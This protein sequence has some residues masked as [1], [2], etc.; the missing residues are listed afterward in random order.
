MR[1]F[2]TLIAITV[3]FASSCMSQKDLGEQTVL[4]RFDKTPCFGQCPTYTMTFYSNGT[5]RL[6][7]KAHLDLL[8]IYELKM[9]KKQVKQLVER[10]DEIGFC[11]LEEEYGTGIS[12]FPSTIISKNCSGKHKTVTAVVDMPEDLA[13][14]IN[15]T[16][17]LLAEE[18]WVVI[19]KNESPD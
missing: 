11:K 16:H 10:L 1:F 13:E 3:L 18:K 2:K 7:G 12:D 17:N 9:K 5:V 6:D 4:F 19:S 8:G 15:E 14:F